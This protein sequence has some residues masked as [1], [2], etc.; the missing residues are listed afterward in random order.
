[1][2]IGVTIAAFVMTVVS[3]YGILRNGLQLLHEDLAARKQVEEDVKDMYLN[4]KHQESNLNRWK[5]KWYICEYTPDE[6]LLQYWGED[7]TDTIKKKL[8]RI[9]EDL[10]KARKALDK[11]SGLRKVLR[12]LAFIALYK[13][14]TQDLIKGYAENMIIIERESEAGW[15]EQRRI[16]NTQIGF[17]SQR[18][19]Q[20]SYLLI[21]IAMQITPDAE[22]LRT[23]CQNVKH[24]IAVLLDLDLFH[25]SAPKEVF[26]NIE[27]FT[28]VLGAGHL[29]LELLLRE[30][31]RH[32]E[33]LTRVVVE[34]APDGELVESRDI[35]A[36]KAIL[37]AG[38]V[39]PHRHHFSFNS[40][41]AF[42]M[43]KIQ[44]KENV[45]SRLH[46]A[47]YEA[48]GCHSAPICDANTRQLAD[49]AVV[50]GE[51]SNSRAAFELTQLCLLFLRNSWIANI[52][53]CRLRFGLLPDSTEQ[54]MYHFGLDMTMTTH[55]PPKWPD[56][57]NHGNCVQGEL[58]HS[59][60]AQNICYWN[61]L[62][63]PIRYLGLLLVEFAL[64]TAV[65]PIVDST[66]EGAAKV[67][68]IHILNTV[69]ADP[70]NWAWERINLRAVLRLVK[71]SFNDS[72]RIAKAVQHCLTASFP[73][74]PSDSEWETQLKIFYF[75]VV[76]PWVICQYYCVSSNLVR[77]MDLYEF[78]ST[79]GA[80]VL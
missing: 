19:I 8:I 67:T 53:R 76:K 43:S 80:L 15:D 10:T 25:S 16:L 14:P 4:I 23:S 77:F 13:K 49:H 78:R 48:L 5:R 72:D 62:N 57:L 52:C 68:D 71:R 31:N 42:R 36:F 70:R 79:G 7:A 33:E 56:P 26:P 9:K 1:M 75:K 2:P 66:T 20:V 59:W 27:R 32:Q 29:K 34:K 69:D 60:C 3:W 41:R 58:I 22:A 63:K 51:V 44:R 18:D 54:Q 64:G 21:R 74:T 45:C 38:M 73:P 11:V 17:V 65:F 37:G 39:D 24:D 61:S 30:T 12:K 40:L 50:L 47:F 28:Q 6:V 55:H 46:Q 35:D